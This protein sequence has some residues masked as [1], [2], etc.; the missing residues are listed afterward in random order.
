[1]KMQPQL[2]RVTELEAK[3]IEGGLIGPDGDLNDF[4]RIIWPYIRPTAVAKIGAV[5]K[6]VQFRAR[7]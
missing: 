3:T 6:D 1:M 5:I 2:Q 7:F 4:P